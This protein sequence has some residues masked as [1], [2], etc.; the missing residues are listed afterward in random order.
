MLTLSFTARGADNPVTFGGSGTAV[1]Y[2]VAPAPDG[3]W[4]IG[5]SFEGTVDFAPGAASTTLTANG[6]DGFFARMTALGELVWVKSFG[7]ASSDRVARMAVAPDGGLYVF[8]EYSIAANFTSAPP[9]D[10]DPGPGVAMSPAGPGMALAKYRP[11]GSFEWARFF[12]GT[13]TPYPRALALTLTGEIVLSGGFQ[14][15]YDFDPGPG[16]A[17]EES[18]PQA[19]FIV[20]LT[21]TGDYVSSATYRS[22]GGTVL[23]ESIAVSRDGVVATGTFYG[24]VD[25]DPGAGSA[26]RVSANGD[27]Y[28][29]EFSVEGRLRWVQTFGGPGTESARG[30]AVNSAGEIFVVGLQGAFG[31]TSTAPTGLSEFPQTRANDAFLWKLTPTGQLVWARSVQSADLDLAGQV[32]VSARGDP[33]VAGLNY[34]SAIVNPGANAVTFPTGAFLWSVD[35]NGVFQW[36]RGFPAANPP[37]INAVVPAGEN[38]YLAGTFASPMDIDPSPAVVNVAP[39]GRFDAFGV[40]LN[41]NGLLTPLFA[42]SAPEFAATVGVSF[43][44]TL[45]VASRAPVTF[46]ASNLPPGLSLT[47]NGTISGTPTARGDYV[48]ALTATGGGGTRSATV[49]IRVTGSAAAQLVNVSSRVQVDGGGVLIA[50]FVVQGTEPRRLLIRGIGPALGGFNVTDFIDDPLLRLESGG[51]SVAVNDDWATANG[52]GEMSAVAAAAGAFPLP[53]NSRDAALLVTLAPGNYTAVIENRAT[54]RGSALAEVYDV[55]DSP[56]SRLV[57]LSTRAFSGGSGAELIAGFALAGAAPRTVLIRAVGPSLTPFGVENAHPNPM[58]RVFA[59]S[60]EVARNDDWSTNGAAELGQ[61]MTRVGA[62]ALG[63]ASRDAAVV[64]RLAPGSYTAVVEANGA[65]SGVA[66]IEVYEV[67]E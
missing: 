60:N 26:S 23:A 65:T 50:G 9:V 17:I 20:R 57:N 10:V 58:L 53:A 31:T 47:P 62:F 37:T 44:E 38:L 2:T 66:L 5:G 51:A 33:I 3:S 67:P 49:T 64:L 11:D 63:V 45:R 32:T 41:E 27:V 52:A 21:A 13:S 56:A 34:S 59:G 15:R 7:S 43:A 48:V 18:G 24:T 22:Q 19:A 1:A 35:R 61:T 42:P 12:A 55:T 4:Y 8:S 54:R 28:V 36:V 25:F 6:S 30:L 40:V 16:T 39:T 14:G 29:A 46:S